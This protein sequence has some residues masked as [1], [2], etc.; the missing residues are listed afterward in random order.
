MLLLQQRW[1]R[2]PQCPVVVDYGHPLSRGLI[3]SCYNSAVDARKPPRDYVRGKIGSLTGTTGIVTTIP[4]SNSPALTHTWNGTSSD[5]GSITIDL[6]PYRTISVGFWLWWDTNGTDN[7]NCLRYVQSTSGTVGWFISPNF[8]AGGSGA[9]CISAW[10]NGSFYQQTLTTRPSTGAWHHFVCV[11][12]LT[13]AAKCLN[14]YV[15]GAFAPN[16]AFASTFSGTS[17]S[18][19]ANAPLFLMQN[20]NTPSFSAGRISNVCIWGR[21]LKEADANLLYRRPWEMFMPPQRMYGVDAVASAPAVQHRW[22]L[23][24]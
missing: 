17:S 8:N 22:F 15:D 20:P 13:L 19:T 6:S 5:D 12:D 18:F 2:Q 9:F 23:M 1:S 7:K 4:P 10:N 14:N 21:S 24:Q 11:I 3:F 16:T